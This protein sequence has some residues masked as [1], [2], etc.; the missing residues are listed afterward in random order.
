MHVQHSCLRLLCLTDCCWI[1]VLHETGDLVFRGACLVPAVCW[2]S[3][4]FGTLTTFLRRAADLLWYSAAR[5]KSSICFRPCISRRFDDLSS[6]RSSWTFHG[7]ITVKQMGFWRRYHQWRIGVDLESRLAC[8]SILGYGSLY[9]RPANRWILTIETASPANL[10][11]SGSFSS[12]IGTSLGTDFR[13]FKCFGWQSC[14]GT[15]GWSSRDREDFLRSCQGTKSFQ[16]GGSS[17]LER[18]SIDHG[19]PHWWCNITL[20]FKFDTTRPSN[21]SCQ[22]I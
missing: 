1:D 10:S 9:F 21:S 19:F 18:R 2:D 4:S 11:V 22:S 3:K 8:Y 7:Y 16:W 6:R 17:N 14:K 15:T 12:S 20:T 13:C 5:G